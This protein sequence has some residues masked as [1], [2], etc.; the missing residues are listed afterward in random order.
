MRLILE[1][2]IPRIEDTAKAAEELSAVFSEGDTIALI[3]DLGTG[4]TTLTQLICQRWNISGVDSPS[5][6]LVNEY[7]GMKRIFHFDFYRIEKENELFDFGFHEYIND[8]DAVKFVEWADMFPEILP[9]KKYEVKLSLDENGN[10]Q[11]AVY[12]YE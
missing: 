1:R 8:A 5:F 4:K 3:G 6:A 7:Y 10:R 12:K 2:S 11:I 9:R